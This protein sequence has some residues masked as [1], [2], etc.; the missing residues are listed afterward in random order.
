[1]EKQQ[2]ALEIG[3]MVGAMQGRDYEECRSF[4]LAFIDS[5]LRSSDAE[6]P[7]V[8]TIVEMRGEPDRLSPSVCGLERSGQ[9]AGES[10]HQEQ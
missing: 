2:M 7:A 4:A 3:G 10:E 9:A 6:L 5:K 8:Q 1:M